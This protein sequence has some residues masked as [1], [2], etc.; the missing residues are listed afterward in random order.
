MK[1]S[2]FVSVEEEEYIIMKIQ[3]LKFRIII[4]INKN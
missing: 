4:F 1:F 3:I 2:V